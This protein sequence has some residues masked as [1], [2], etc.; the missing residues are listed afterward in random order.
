MRV[1]RRP[2]LVE[3]LEARALLSL[4]PTLTTLTT[5]PATA[6]YGQPVT[7]TAKV[8]TIPAGKQ[9]PTGGTVSFSTPSAPLGTAPLI[10]GTATL[11]VTSLAAGTDALVAVYG[12]NGTDAGSASTALTPT[13]L[14]ST[15]TSVPVVAGDAG[16]PPNSL[17]IDSAGNL[18]I[19]ESGDNVV[20]EI[21]KATGAIITVAGNGIAGYTGDAG[22]P[23][24]AELHTPAGVAVDSEGNLF[25]SDWANNVVRE[26]V[27]ATGDIITVAGNGT[28]GPVN[29]GDGGPAINA[30]VDGPTG[31]AV[32]SDGNLFISDGTTVVRE[33]VKATGIIV[34]FA[35]TGLAA[36]SGDGGPPTSADL[37]DTN[38]LAFD[39]AGD[40]FIAGQFTVREVVKATG[41]ITTAAGQF[42]GNP[43]YSGDGGPATSALFGDVTGVAVDSAGNLFLADSLDHVVREVVAAT[44]NI[45]TVAGTGTA[46]YSGDGGPAT[47]AELRDPDSV[48][49]DSAGNLF[50]DDAGNSR[51][52]EVQPQPT[53]FIT[54]SP[55]VT[56]TTLATAP[57][58]SVYGQ[59]VTLTATVS[60]NAP[61]TRTPAG[62]VIFVQT[63][64]TNTFGK[65]TLD[66]RGV[67]AV[68]VSDLEP[69][70]YPITAIYQGSQN[71]L[72]SFSASLSQTVNKS[73]TTTTVAAPQSPS[74]F[75]Q[76]VT[77]TVTVTGDP[78]LLV[79][80]TGSVVIDVDGK[81]LTNATLTDAS[82][83]SIDVT[84]S[85]LPVGQHSITAHYEG[86]TIFRDSDS[87]ALTLTVNRDTTAIALTS[88]PSPAV[89]GQGVTFT[90]TVTVK[91]PGAGTPL[92]TVTFEDNGVPIGTGTLNATHSV[93]LATSTLAVATH[94]ITAVYSGDANDAASTSKSL[95]QVVNRA[96]TL[97]TLVSSLNPSAIGRSVTFTATVIANSPG[98][99]T[100]GGTVTFEEKGKVLGTI[101]L[102]AS[103]VATFAT[104][105]LTAASHVITAVFA[106]NGSY[107]ASTSGA[108]TE[109]IKRTGTILGAS[110]TLLASANPSVYG[111]AVTFTATVKPLKAGV[112][113][114]TGTVSYMEGTALLGKAT[115]DRNGAARL[116]LSSLAAGRDPIYV[117]Y[118]GDA[119]FSG[120]GSTVLVERV[121]PATTLTKLSSSANPSRHGQAVTLTATVTAVKPGAGVPGGTVRFLDGTVLLGTAP[122]GKTG[123]A[124]LRLS[125]LPS[126]V[127]SLTAVYVGSARFRGS[128]S[129]VVKQTVGS[130]VA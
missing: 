3:T 91:S 63:G 46:G 39:A 13:S 7:L 62:S 43:G 58:P 50:I 22:S 6:V 115:L 79:R 109:V 120:N 104:S 37:Q 29:Q 97:I 33:V 103:G 108:L 130:G 95:S 8:T 47:D 38:E 94:L 5:S 99:G 64:T 98:D 122:L 49:V 83:G 80:P 69:G 82:A 27:K 42:T 116:T 73:P 102:D 52:R 28:A 30:E 105:A 106:G 113:I 56:T 101:T 59:T 53:T 10:N 92:G 24:D 4:A 12:G 11:T 36:N 74:V 25:I 77:F 75:G 124:T 9:P 78:L 17:A 44:G 88:S 54:I 21:V 14:I 129:A 60:P 16:P 89:T 61:S 26:V 72:T 70:T 107:Q 40:L 15:V 55:A 121:N 128:T 23:T 126:G 48:A 20:R 93:T 19:A 110:T 68:T 117:V 86:T 76:P 118:Q 71:D 100:P 127:Q 123:R 111:Q 84:T 18:F 119:H 41:T 2:W 45:I 35:G 32:D 67:A 65:A 1:V 85:A 51:I 112:G 90:A 114:P 87:P 81:P 66:A 125:S 31:L 34:P 57:A 96:T